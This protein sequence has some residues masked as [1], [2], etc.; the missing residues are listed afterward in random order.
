MHTCTSRPE[1]LTSRSLW[2]SFRHAIMSS[3]CMDAP[4]ENARR[5]SAAW[6]WNFVLPIRDCLEASGFQTDRHPD[7][8]LQGI[9]R[10]NICN[11]GRRRCGVQLELSR[12]LRDELRD[13]GGALATFAAAI[14]AALPHPWRCRCVRVQGP[15]GC[16]ARTAL[17]AMDSDVGRSAFSCCMAACIPALAPALWKPDARP[18]TSQRTRFYRRGA[19][20][21]NRTVSPPTAIWAMIVHA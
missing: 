2:G 5:F 14:R 17:D 8:D 9:S 10:R 18:A 12:D 20:R 11:K 19:R 7:P 16:L 4:R 15:A 13:D 6:T 3:L 21:Q 1:T